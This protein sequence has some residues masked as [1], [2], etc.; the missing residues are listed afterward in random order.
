MVGVIEFAWLCQAEQHDDYGEHADED[1]EDGD[2]D[3]R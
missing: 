3:G 2:S 1:E